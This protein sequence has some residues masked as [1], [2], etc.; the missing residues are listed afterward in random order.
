M[1]KRLGIAVVL[2]LCIGGAG[3]AQGPGGGGG[4]GGT[5][6]GGAATGGGGGGGATGGG[7]GGIKLKAALIPSAEY[8]GAVGS[9]NYTQSS[10][11]TTL[12]A[13]VFNTGLP[14]DSWACE[15]VD[16]LQIQC[17]VIMDT[18]FGLDGTMFS[19]EGR[20]GFAPLNILNNVHAGSL[21]EIRTAPTP[22]G[23]VGGGLFFQID[24]AHPGTLIA[25][26]ILH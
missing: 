14:I 7:G 8:P 6:G 16:G 25:S 19:T 26:G 17:N 9:V 13:S 12:R 18:V 24:P 3:L 20:T 5:G 15:Y 21:Y 1:I 10:L 4:G 2:V 23:P 22:T 11:T